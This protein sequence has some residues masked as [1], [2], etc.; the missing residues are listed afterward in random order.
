MSGESDSRPIIAASALPSWMAL[1]AAWPARG[2]NVEFSELMPLIPRILSV[3]AQEPV[4]TL[5]AAMRLP[6]SSVKSSSAS[7]AR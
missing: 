1:T 5:P 6:L 4:L 3:T 2:N 7:V